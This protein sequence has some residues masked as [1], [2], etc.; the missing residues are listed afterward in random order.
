MFNVFELCWTHLKHAMAITCCSNE[1]KKKIQKQNRFNFNRRRKSERTC[2]NI[3]TDA[4]NY[5][6]LNWT[7]LMFDVL[8]FL[9]CCFFCLLHHLPCHTLSHF[10]S[11]IKVHVAQYSSIH[12]CSLPE[13]SYKIYNY[14][15]F[16]F[17]ARQVMS[18]KWDILT[19]LDSF[20][21]MASSCS[22]RTSL[23]TCPH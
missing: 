5:S 22:S 21:I 3:I 17:F 16:A 9:R 23:T 1:Q 6:A 7:S 18:M 12:T 11:L 20:A 8:L 13:C 19:C 4:V 10:L 14:R 15:L 2:S